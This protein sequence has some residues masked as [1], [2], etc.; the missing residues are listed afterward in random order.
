MLGIEKAQMSRLINGRQKPTLAQIKLMSDIFSVSVEDLVDISIDQQDQ[1]TDIDKKLVEMYRSFPVSEFIS[2]QWAGVSNISSK[3]D[4]V[5][6]LEPYFADSKQLSSKNSHAKKTHPL[7]EWSSLQQAWILRVRYLASLNV[8]NLG[9]Y[10]PE[11]I[12]DVIAKVGS[13]MHTG[14]SF[15]ELLSTLNTH[16]IQLVIVECKGSKIDGVCTWLDEKHPVIGMTIRFNRE[17]NFWFVLLHELAH[18]KQ[19]FDCKQ[20]FLDDNLNQSSSLNELEDQAN[21]QA[22]EVCLPHE[23]RLKLVE[24]GGNYTEENVRGFA[25]NYSLNLAVL[26]GQ[27]RHMVNKYTILNRTLKK[28]RDEVCQEA[29]IVDGW[30][31]Q[32]W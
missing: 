22:Q 32:K 20:D 30:G 17:D 5:R 24:L 21:Q 14:G 1:V 25:E 31:Y 8:A 12:D 18:V 29:P 26:S 2:K 9:T 15:S 11:C 13:I 27:I 19:G 16:G 10:D 3:E 4:L 7:A 6:A 28:I 23:L